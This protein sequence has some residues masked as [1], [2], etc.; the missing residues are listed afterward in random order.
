MI[1]ITIIIIALLIKAA[2]KLYTKIK[3]KLNSKEEFLFKKS[4]SILTIAEKNFYQ[5]LKTALIDTDYFICIKI[6]LDNVLCVKGNKKSSI[7]KLTN[8]QIDFL[9][10][11]DS[12]YFNPILAIELDDR[13]YN[14]VD[15]IVVDKFIEKVY[16]SAKL[17]F[18]RVNTNNPYSTNELRDEI[19]KLSSCSDK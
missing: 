6:N 16:D 9:I 5:V 10:C 15:K 3:N 13:C 8:K 7:K 17:P 2:V 4:N 14:N 11:S 19:Y 1:C 18:L 12:I